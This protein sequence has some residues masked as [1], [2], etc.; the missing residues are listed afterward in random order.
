V[1]A[2]TGPLARVEILRP[3]PPLGFVHPLVADAVLLTLAPGER[4][5]Q[6]AR[7]A[8]MLH[9][10]GAPAEQVAGHLVRAPRGGEPWV[11]GVLRD[12]ARTAV[13]RGAAESATT[14]LRRALDEPAAAGEDR[15][16]MLLETG[17]VEAMASGPEAVDHLREALAILT[18]PAQRALA[19]ATLGR[20]CCSRTMRP[21]PRRSSTRS[22]PASATSTPISGT[23]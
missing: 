23:S 15:G 13:R 3:E 16:A 4:E 12:A 5:L 18:D 8:R 17:L 1:A 6:H 14:F 2:V 11:V 10:A 22:R 19:A 7:A 21:V 20:S 9:A